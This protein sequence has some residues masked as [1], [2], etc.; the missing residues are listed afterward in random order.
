MAGGINP[1]LRTGAQREK[2]LTLQ[3]PDGCPTGEGPTSN[4]DRRTGPRTKDQR[5]LRRF[6]PCC[7]RRAI[8]NPQRQHSLVGDRRESESSLGAGPGQKGHAPRV[9][10]AGNTGKPDNATIITGPKPG[11]YPLRG[12][13]PESFNR[14]HR[15][16]NKSSQNSSATR[17]C[18]YFHHSPRVSQ[19]LT[20]CQNSRLAR[21]L[22]VSSSAVR[23]QLT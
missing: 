3:P 13:L 7:L 17:P 16:F 19:R 21:A 10:M 4:L 12:L 18:P 5:Q 1:N 6:G 15:H 22:R 14:V 2:G 20:R 8:S 11:W 23:R 9:S